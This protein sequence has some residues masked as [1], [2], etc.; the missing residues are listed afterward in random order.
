MDHNPL[1]YLHVNKRLL[2]VIESNRTKLLLEK[3]NPTELNLLLESLNDELLALKDSVN[4]ED[5]KDCLGLLSKL[6][7]IKNELEDLERMEDGLRQSTIFIK[8][9]FIVITGVLL[10]RCIYR[11]VN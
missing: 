7:R 8:K 6:E 1:K 9:L 11:L 2:D 4:E 5:I 3:D 10:V